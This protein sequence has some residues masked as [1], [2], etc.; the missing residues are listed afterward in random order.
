VPLPWERTGP[1]LGFGSG[2]G[3]LPQP[4]GWADLSVEAEDEDRGSMLWLY[5][6]ALALRRE[7]PQL[8]AGGGKL[9]WTGE[10]PDVLG[11]T[12]DGGFICI[13][14]T[15]SV[16]VPLPPGRVVRSSLP[17]E[18]NLL[19]ADAAAWIVTG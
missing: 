4:A 6:D 12:R 18:G 9:T 7:L 15:G 10:E 1:S 3:W 19:P 11:F 16:P 5:R 17:T 8:G 2:P 14:N 13:V